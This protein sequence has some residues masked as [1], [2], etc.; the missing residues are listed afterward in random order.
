MSDPISVGDQV[1][2]SPYSSYYKIVGTV[3]SISGEYAEIE[4]SYFPDNWGGQERVL[5]VWLDFFYRYMP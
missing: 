2:G 1:R 5:A 3:L 4:V